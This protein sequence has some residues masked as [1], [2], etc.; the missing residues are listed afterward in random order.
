MT[1]PTTPSFLWHDY[2]TF[3]ANVRVDR[4][5]EFAC[6]RSNEAFEPIAE[7]V[8]F[9]C[10]PTLD[11][12]PQ[13]EACVI[14]GIGPESA[15]REGL[16][17]PEFAERVLAEMG[18]PQTCVLGYNSMR[19]DDEIT[20]YLFWRNFIDPYQREWA[21]GNSRFDLIDLA[22]AAQ[23][24]RPGGIHWPKREDGHPSFRLSDLSAANA[25]PHRHAHAALSD[26]EA[27]LA[28][29]R[30]IR[31]TQPRLMSFALGLRRKARVLEL[32]DWRLRKPV[33][34][35]SQRFPAERGCLAQVLPLAMHPNQS[36]KVIVVDTFQDPTPLL[37]WTAERL[38][39]MLLTP[40]SDPDRVAVGL[41]VVHANRAPFLAPLSVLEGVDLERIAFDRDRVD[42]HTQRLQD[43]ADLG[44]KLQQVYALLDRGDRPAQDP[45]EALYEGFVADS[46]RAL[47][48]RWRVEAETGLEALSKK[49]S[50]PRLQTL[51]FRFR[52]RHHEGSLGEP[53][54]QLW[55]RHCRGRLTGA[56][57]SLDQ[58]RAEVRG[59]SEQHPQLADEL[60]QWGQ[61]LCAHAQ[62]SWPQ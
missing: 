56:E 5:A 62:L 51:A 3:G 28:L 25:L 32:L 23:A 50:D 36:G 60:T 41:K 39:D 35:V 29:A 21:H 47:S 18:T 15:W 1:A 43:A 59:I 7:P 46:D 27:T 52:A 9:R 57:H 22:R 37:E 17:E 30:L 40:A 42:L 10:R 2:E 55:L 19:F 34:H 54:Q 20:R 12:L 61:R 8:A 58:Y 24:L 13:P 14:T 6:W 38:A 31:T 45:D 11:Y 44:Q 48:T 16:P 26:V 49:F 33:V 4:P 53:E